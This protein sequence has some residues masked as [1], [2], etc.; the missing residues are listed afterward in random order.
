MI[1]SWGFLFF[2]F[3]FFIITELK[4]PKLDYS[5]NLFLLESSKNMFVS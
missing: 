1:L 5:K 4:V 3:V 2:C